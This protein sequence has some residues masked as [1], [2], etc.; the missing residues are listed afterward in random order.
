MA[1]AAQRDYYEILGVPRNAT[2]KQIKDAFR[3]LAMKL[4]PDRN[5]SPDA[6]ER[7][8]EVAAA[9][10]VLSDPAKRRDYDERGFAGVAGFSEEDLFRNV[11]FQDLF[12][13]LNFD[14]AGLGAG[15]G[16]GL[17]G[18][19]FERFFGRR[20]AGPPRGENIEIELLVPLARVASGGE[21]Q[22]R[23]TRPLT[24]SKCGGSGAKEG[25]RPRR[26]SACEGTGRKTQQSRRRRGPGEVLVQTVY[27]CPDC[28]GRGEIIEQP[29]PDCGGRGVSQREESLTV[30][31]PV[32][33]EEGMA[34]RIPG[35]GLPSSTK[36][37]VPGDLFVI[38][39]SSP[40]PR[41]ERA[42]AD[43]WRT[44]R[45]TVPEAVLGAT[46]RIQ[47]LEGDVDVK[48]PRSSQPD[49]VLRLQGKGLP[50]FGARGRGDLFLRLRVTVP[51][52]LTS[53]Q[54][55]LYQQLRLLEQPGTPPVSNRRARSPGATRERKE[56]AHP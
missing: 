51:E 40:D 29:C 11:D 17:G 53:Q 15:L 4:H 25:T 20:H 54:R 36:G 1:T 18:G 46:H 21:E 56:G 22:V 41:F 6:E 48:I 8:K 7:F 31:V 39:R 42:G 19:L 28:N 13:G 23:Y 3:T 2:E 14:F 32:G 45:L 37:G 50:Q 33:V 16:G 24:C 26:C 43:L 10:A 35:H 9:Y 30:N 44:E 47:T 49:S 52:E 34:L 12:G 5:K 55:E 38:V 27:P